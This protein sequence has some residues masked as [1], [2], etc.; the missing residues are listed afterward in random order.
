MAKLQVP[1]TKSKGSVE[2]DTDTIPE[3]VFAEALLQGLKVLVNR[4]M[5]KVTKETYPKADELKA[6]A[7]AK[8]EENVVAINE[9]KVKLSGSGGKAKKAS[10]A[11]MTEARRIAKNLVKDEMKRLGIKV[12]H[13][14]S[15]EITKAANALLDED[16][17]ILEQA[18]AN[19]AEREKVDVGSKIDLKALIVESPELVAKAE[20]RKA[21]AKAGAPLSA[22]QAGMTAKHKP[23]SQAVH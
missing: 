9:G 10:G 7:Q 5:S 21:K 16:P 11:V 13:V 15:S 22:K 19:L 2:I 8:A 6:A 12:S 18:T 20:A 17:T 1:V 23:Q 3:A 14:A 4:G